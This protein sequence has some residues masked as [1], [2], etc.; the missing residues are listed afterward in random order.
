MIF[1]S[2]ELIYN[3]YNAIGDNKVTNVKEVVMYLDESG[4]PYLPNT[5]GA[6][7]ANSLKIIVNIAEVCRNNT[8]EIGLCM[9]GAVWE[10]AKGKPLVRHN[11]AISINWADSVFCQSSFYAQDTVRNSLSENAI[12]LR[13]YDTPSE[14]TQGGLGHFN[15]ISFTYDY[16]YVGGTVLLLL[17]PTEPMFKVSNPK[18]STSINFNF[19]H[20]RNP[21]GLG[22]SFSAAGFGVSI[23]A[24]S[25]S[26]STSNTKDF[27]FS[28]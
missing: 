24:G 9:Y 6:I 1:F 11:D 14:A 23:D 27:Y 15:N 10:W 16:N 17:A 4:I 28:R 2:E 20:N 13:D 18:Y 8:N 7:D 19:V 12:V 22:V 26:D 3:I 25:M 21:L 5:L